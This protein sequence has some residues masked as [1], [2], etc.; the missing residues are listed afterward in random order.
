MI[1]NQPKDI[2]FDFDGVIAQYDGFKGT[3]HA[4][5]PIPSMVEV[6]RKLKD[7][8]HSI[9]IY[10]TRGND[11]LRDYCRKYEIPVDYFNENPNK[12]G[13]NPGKPI[14]YVYVDD[15]SV[16]YKGQDSESLFQEIINFKA[17]WQK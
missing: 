8:G 16:T 11:F 4:G 13:A 1:H 17:Y 5:E 9:I 12:Q 15:R 14:A 2:A 7:L 6:I 10:S 3:E